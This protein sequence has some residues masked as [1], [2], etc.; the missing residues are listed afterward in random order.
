MGVAVRLP[1]QGLIEST[2][3]ARYDFSTFF[4]PDPDAMVPVWPGGQPDEEMDLQAALGVE[5]YRQR[6]RTAR[7]PTLHPTPV[8]ER[9][10]NVSVELFFYI[11]RFHR[12]ERKTGAYLREARGMT[13]A[14]RSLELFG[15]DDAWKLETRLFVC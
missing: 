1:A 9:S 10:A 6:W 2:A 12:N 7:R 5:G 14:Y 11:P 4:S 13:E 3:D 15:S 8:A